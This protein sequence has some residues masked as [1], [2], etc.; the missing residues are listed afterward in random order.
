MIGVR[1]DL[2]VLAAQMDRTRTRL[3]NLEGLAGRF[4]A[5]QQENRE[6][7]ERQYQRLGLRIAVL[8]LV[9]G[10]AAVVVPLVTILLTGK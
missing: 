5:N 7:E 6:R 8:T 4:M 1:E 10:C 9:V 3:H 2:G